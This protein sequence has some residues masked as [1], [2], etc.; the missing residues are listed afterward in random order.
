MRLRKGKC[1]KCTQDV[2]K[3]KSHTRLEFS[4]PS[5]SKNCPPNSHL[6]GNLMIYIENKRAVTHTVWAARRARTG[7]EVP[8]WN[9][10]R[11]FS[12]GHVLNTTFFVPFSTKSI[13]PSTSNYMEQLCKFL[14]HQ[15]E[16]A[17]IYWVIIEYLRFDNK[18]EAKSAHIIEA[19]KPLTRRS[20]L[21]ILWSI[22]S[23]PYVIW[24]P[25]SAASILNG[26][27]P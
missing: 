13:V 21:M 25:Y 2:L 4:I 8:I 22:I 3:L 18:I 27:V 10:T 7:S 9:T 1:Y 26:S 24:A 12:S 17:S 19:N 5:H 15:D 20:H 16:C 6:N 14:I 11:F 23:S